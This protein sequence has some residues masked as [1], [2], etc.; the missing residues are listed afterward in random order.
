MFQNFQ[1]ELKALVSLFSYFNL[2][3][4]QTYLKSMLLVFSVVIFFK[5]PTYVLFD[6]H[7][8]CRVM[9]TS[10]QNVNNIYQYSGYTDRL[11]I[12]E[13]TLNCCHLSP[14]SPDT[15]S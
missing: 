14:T 7:F 3:Q 15:L 1:N 13:S 11:E 9:G 10:G 2:V 5:L 12:L 4:S 6:F 8:H